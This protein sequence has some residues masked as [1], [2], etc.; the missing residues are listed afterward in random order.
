[1]GILT[2]LFITFKMSCLIYGVFALAN[3]FYRI[4][5]GEVSTRGTYN[6]LELIIYSILIGIGIT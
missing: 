1:L 6:L 4:Y 5:W 2:G 3:M